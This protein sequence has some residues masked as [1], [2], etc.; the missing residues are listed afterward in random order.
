MHPASDTF[1]S[2]KVESIINILKSNLQQWGFIEGQLMEPWR[3]FEY[4][5]DIDTS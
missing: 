5:R 4:A 2:V 3:E 1:D